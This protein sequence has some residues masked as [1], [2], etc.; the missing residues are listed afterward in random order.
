MQELQRTSWDEIE[1]VVDTALYK[2]RPDDDVDGLRWDVQTG[3]SMESLLRTEGWRFVYAFV[4]SLREA[5]VQQLVS[6]SGHDAD[7]W[8]Q[9]VRMLELVLKQPAKS[10]EDGKRAREVLKA[11]SE[12]GDE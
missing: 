7:N 3:A 10:I 9:A 6:G 8:R 5:C 1:L 12:G 2:T 11:Y 4:L